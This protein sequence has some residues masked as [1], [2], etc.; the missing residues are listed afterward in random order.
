MILHLVVG[1][2]GYET[3]Y[4]KIGG[5]ETLKQIYGVN[6]FLIFPDMRKKQYWDLLITL[7]ILISCLI[8]PWR[9]AFVE[10]EDNFWWVLIDGIIDILFLL[11]IVLNFFSVYP[12]E[13]EDYV[14]D[15]KMIALTYLKGWFIFDVASILPINLFV[16]DGEGVNDLARL[17]RLP[18][19]YKLVKIF[20]I[21]KQGDKIKKHAAEILK[22]GMI[23]ERLITFSIIL[24][25]TTH[26]LS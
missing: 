14:T 13:Y 24:F 1:N 22:I 25:L 7:L 10:D 12:N 5:K 18:R 9:L 4:S 20:R 16:S 3:D 26:F 2:L 11:D 19:L 8:T 21:V 23:L 6:K 17:A 15:R